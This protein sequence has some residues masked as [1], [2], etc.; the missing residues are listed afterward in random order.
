MLAKRGAATAR[1]GPHGG[2]YGSQRTSWLITVS[3]CV[4][5][6]WAG[7][8]LYYWQAGHLAVV[9]EIEEAVIKAEH[10][11]EDQLKHIHVTVPINHVPAHDTSVKEHQVVVTEPSD[12]HVIFSTDC[13]PYQ[14][15]QSLVLFHS[16]TVV[17]QPGPLTR[18]ASGCDEAKKKELTLLYKKLYPQYHVHFTPDFKK[19]DK[20][21]VS[22][23]Y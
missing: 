7:F 13:K 11:V 9:Q 20:T 22:C 23:K 17:G 14:D 16:A 10:A 1:G 6:T 2:G 18:I 4:M 8:M 3:W 21:G 5:V 15:W 12:I 19:D